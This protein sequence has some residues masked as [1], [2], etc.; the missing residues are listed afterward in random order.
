MTGG[1]LVTRFRDLDDTHRSEIMRDDLRIFLA[2]PL[3]GVGPGE[4]R[5]NRTGRPRMAHTEFT[6]LLAEHGALGLISALC[7]LL[8]GIG[9]VVRARGSADRALAVALVSWSCL[10]MLH[11]AMRIAAPAFAFGLAFAFRPARPRRA[12]PR[13]LE[14]PG[15]ELAA[16]EESGEP[17]VALLDEA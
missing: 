6:R 3:T 14:P 16:A 4:A 2:H 11:A 9:A 12:T 10:T 17:A 5:H 13:V 1:T 8:L 7:L 15:P